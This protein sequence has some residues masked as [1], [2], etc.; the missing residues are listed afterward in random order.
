MKFYD[1]IR[2]DI[3]DAKMN[4]DKKTYYRLNDLKYRYE[5]QQIDIVELHESKCWGEYNENMPRKK[6]IMY[7]NDYHYFKT[8]VYSLICSGV[9]EMKARTTICVK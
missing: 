4:N 9:I 8:Y 1:K 7:S 6:Q 5:M 2:I 3:I